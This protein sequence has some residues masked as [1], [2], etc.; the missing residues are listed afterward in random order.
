M[1]YI[2]SIVILTLVSCKQ[3]PLEYTLQYKFTSEERDSMEVRIASEVNF[4]YEGSMMRQA[5]LDTL[6]AI[7][8]EKEEY[9]RKKS[10]KF[11][12]RGDFHKAYPLMREAVKLD[13]LTSLYFTSW[14]LLFYYRDYERALADL[15]YYD[16]ISKGVDYI[17]GENI[18][19]LK[20]LAYKQME[21]YDQAVEEFDKSLR[22]EKGTGTEYIHVY[23]GISNLR[24][25]CLEE[26][27]KDFEKAISIDENC[28]MGYVYL[29]ESLMNIKSYDEALKSLS[30]AEGLL[31]KE[32]KM[33]NPNFEV[34]DEVQLVQVY[35]LLD[36]IQFLLGNSKEA[37]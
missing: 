27:I 7:N 4:L 21:L 22:S 6:I 33:R 30:K 28:T 13:P 16:D 12:T 35:D 18:H 19:Y 29:G 14:Q 11:S 8:D 32:A 34:F 26:S 36:E 9:F 17:R 25:E 5:K 37:I 1:K 15:N 24:N 3:L 20:G 23:R 2:L 31:C 10:T